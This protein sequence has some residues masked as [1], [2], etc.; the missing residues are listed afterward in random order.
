MIRYLLH[1]VW[2]S[3]CPVCGKIGEDLCP[4]CCSQAMAPSGPAC[5]LCGGPVPCE[6]HGDLEWYSAAPHSGMARELV[7]SLKYGGKAKIGFEMG[8]QMA[9]TPQKPRDAVVIPV[10]LHR[11][12]PRKY[13]QAR[14]IASGVSKAW[15]FP[16]LDRLKWD[17]ALSCQTSLSGSDRSDMPMD[18]LIWNGP[19]LEGHGAVIVDDVKTTGVTLYRAYLALKRASPAGV[20]FLTWSRSVA[21][22][23]KGGIPFGT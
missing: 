20:L 23:L 22:K 21:I 3:S 10:P 5:L 15:G 11:G 1:L 19:S 16:L 14:W 6:V 7:L 8:R 13:N 2:P 17:K 4:T 12:S 9:S 18:A